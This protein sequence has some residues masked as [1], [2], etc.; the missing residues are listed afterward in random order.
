MKYLVMTGYG[1]CLIR[2]HFNYRSDAEMFAASI[3]TEHKFERVLLVDTE[4]SVYTVK[5]AQP[6]EV[7]LLGDPFR[8][9]DSEDNK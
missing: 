7:P 2:G 8:D 5:K 4:A 6:V 1:N 3:L 9:D